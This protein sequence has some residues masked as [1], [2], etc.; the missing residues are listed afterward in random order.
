MLNVGLVWHM[1]EDGSG[2]G[3]HFDMDPAANMPDFDGLYAGASFGL[4]HNPA[5]NFFM[6][7]GFGSHP[8]RADLGAILG[9]NIAL[10]DWV[11]VGV[12]GQAG[13]LFDSSGDMGYN[14]WALGRAGITPLPGVL[15]Y[16]QGGVGMVQGKFAYGA[17][18]GIEYAA[19]DN[20]SVR[21]EALAYGEPGGSRV[22]RR[23]SRPPRSR[24]ASSGTSTDLTGCP[25]RVRG[26]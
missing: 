6:D 10:N 19:F 7:V 14:A 20:A 24:P 15:A 12:E 25:R 1:D 4:H 5:N 8:T 13:L 16:A 21:L 23:R 26:L 11:V 18:G 22:G 17:G 9:W 2:S 3:W